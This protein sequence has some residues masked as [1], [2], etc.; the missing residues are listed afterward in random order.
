[1][2]EKSTVIQI[3]GALMK[4]PQY[5]SETDKYNLTPDDFYY[6][7]DKYIFVAIDSLYRSGATRIQPIDVENYLSTNETAS[8]IFKQQKGIEYLQDADYLALEEN[9]PY[10]YKKL[11]KFNLL[12]SFKDKGIDIREFYVEDALTPEA[13]EVNK[14]FEELEINDIVDA[15]KRKVLG[16]E[17]DFIQN[18]T[19]ETIN[20]FEDIE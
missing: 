13:L 16:V 11:K 14:K 17:R 1:M 20:V 3:F 12:N 5:L 9:F 6:K 4:H 18:D 2:V 15:I 8:I 10:Y 7:F 19:T